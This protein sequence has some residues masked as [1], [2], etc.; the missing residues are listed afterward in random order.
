MPAGNPEPIRQ[1]ASDA[2]RRR[3]AHP[4]TLGLDPVLVALDYGEIPIRVGR[5]LAERVQRAEYYAPSAPGLR[6]S[7]EMSELGIQSRS[8]DVTGELLRPATGASAAG[9]TNWINRDFAAALGQT[10]GRSENRP[11]CP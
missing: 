2:A 6:Q 1:R 7:S 4:A 3:S 9:G 11:T 8:R 5:E 10:V